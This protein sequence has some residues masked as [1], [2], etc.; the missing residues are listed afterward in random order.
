[1]SDRFD[2]RGYLV[3]HVFGQARRQVF[4][5]PGEVRTGSWKFHHGIVARAQSLTRA[6]E[7]LNRM[8]KRNE[9]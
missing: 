2:R 5:I 8:I 6:H 1:M 7:E 3:R 4:A 9:E